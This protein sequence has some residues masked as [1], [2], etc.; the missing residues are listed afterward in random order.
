MRENRG[1][2]LTYISLRMPLGSQARARNLGWACGGLSWT[3]PPVLKSD[4][5]WWW[6]FS[7]KNRRPNT[8]PKTKEEQDKVAFVRRQSYGRCG[9]IFSGIL[10][11]HPEDLPLG[12]KAF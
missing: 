5:L 7:E 8:T 10:L 1:R 12:G 4:S 2:V 3:P 11:P 6:Q 9:V